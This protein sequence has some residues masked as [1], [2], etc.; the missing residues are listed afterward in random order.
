MSDKQIKDG[1]ADAFG[2]WLSQH[3]VTTPDCI[4]SA[5]RE[6]F[7]KWLNENADEIIERIAAKSP[8]DGA[9]TRHTKT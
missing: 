1:V 9:E 3:D 4:E 8:N 2:F 5:I 6:S 7:T